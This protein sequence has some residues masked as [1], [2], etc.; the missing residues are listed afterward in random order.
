MRTSKLLVSFLG[1]VSL[2]VIACGSNNFPGEDGNVDPNGGTIAPPNSTTPPADAGVTTVPPGCDQTQTPSQNA[3]VVIEA[4]GI[5]V[6]PPAANA[7]VDAGEGVADGTRAR[8]Y[9]KLQDA[10]GAAKAQKKRVYACSGDYA[11]QLTLADGVSMFGG[12]DC[13]SWAPIATHVSVKAPASPVVTTNAITTHTRVEAFDFIAPDGTPD[14]P[15]SIALVATASN[16]LTLAHSTLHAGKGA[17]G[18]DGVAAVQLANGTVNGANGLAQYVASSSLPLCASQPQTVNTCVGAPGFAG[19]TGGAGGWG[20]HWVVSAGGGG[21]P[22]VTP[23]QP[24]RLQQCLPGRPCVCGASLGG[25]L[26]A[27]AT[28][29]QGAHPN[30]NPSDP[31]IARGGDGI[32]G[33]VGADGV[34]GAASISLDG[35]LHFFPGDGRPGM[36]GSPGQGGGG[37]NGNAASPSNLNGQELIGNAGASGGAG[38][39]PGLAGTAG[40]GGG[41]SIALLVSDSPLT[42]DTC[43][44]QTSDAGNGGKGALGSSP[45][46][47][48]A[49]GIN[50]GGNSSTAGGSGGAGGASGWSGS[51]AGGWSVGIV[52]HGA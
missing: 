2:G 4:L 42:L 16:A 47:G 6:T 40:K 12:L 49:P 3:C 14:A 21:F 41:A 23:Y 29:A 35:G 36:N 5:F 9:T 33:T 28:T 44:L 25:A 50:Y 27:T 10:I 38:G 52:S 22:S 46:Y 37:G 17:N 43:V 20:G 15:S 18:A 24:P 39:C 19:G 31:G 45:T 26:T 30:G 1:V 34:V 11:E 51:G 32:A 48:G 13:T 8:P 7:A